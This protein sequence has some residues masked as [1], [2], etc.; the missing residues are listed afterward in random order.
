MSSSGDFTYCVSSLLLWAILVAAVSTDA[1][2]FLVIKHRPG[3]TVS[4]SRGNEA[5]GTLHRE[6]MLLIQEA[7]NVPGFGFHHCLSY[8]S[9][10]SLPHY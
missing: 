7:A 4:T 8:F 6:W 3:D 5:L 1:L 10:S 9:A 2:G